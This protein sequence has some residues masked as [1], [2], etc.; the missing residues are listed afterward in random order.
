MILSNDFKT[1][2]GMPMLFCKVIL[3]AG[4]LLLD[5]LDLTLY[6]IGADGL[7]N[8]DGANFAPEII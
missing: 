3:L 4:K 1:G 6:S 5:D 7:L 8:R 2:M